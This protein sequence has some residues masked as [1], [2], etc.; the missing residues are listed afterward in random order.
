MSDFVILKV[1]QKQN[2]NKKLYQISRLALDEKIQVK[3][4]KTK[5]KCYKGDAK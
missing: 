4:K 5:N 2:K 3:K 1:G